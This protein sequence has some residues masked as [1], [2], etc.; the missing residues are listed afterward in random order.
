M[1]A[2]YSRASGVIGTLC[3]VGIFVVLLIAIP[4]P[5]SDIIAF[6]RNQENR[7]DIYLLD[8]DYRI[9]HNFSRS[10]EID[11]ISTR[12]SADGRYLAYLV[13]T[14]QRLAVRVFEPASREILQPMRQHMIMQGVEYA[15]SP[16]G[17]YLVITATL[18]L[19]NNRGVDL[20]RVSRDGTALENLTN[21]T[22][23]YA[24][25][26]YSPEGEEIL[27]SARSESGADI[28]RMQLSSHDGTRLTDDRGADGGAVWS[29]DGE[30]IAFESW[31]DG[32][33]EIYLMN[34]DGTGL[35][36]LTNH[37]E[38]DTEP[39][40]SPDGTQVLFLGVRDGD[41]D[42]YTLELA[43]GRLHQVTDLSNVYG[44]AAWSPDG[45]RIVFQVSRMNGEH[46]MLV[47]ADG[48]HL[49]DLTPDDNFVYDS[50]ATWRP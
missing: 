32:N 21:E 49:R 40:F 31:R 46:L 41:R 48:D 24:E 12:W 13:R 43:T 7:N 35:R 25:L 14:P 19:L 22:A 3:F 2:L 50:E 8:V 44:G 28:Y 18:S 36:N 4:L 33:Y 6:T 42:L 23:N 38:S 37:P 39:R 5:D 34:R 27:F 20:W 29:P 11:E 10:P 30:Q 16:D 9:L 15:W 1:I 47:D 45:E 26:H 17:E